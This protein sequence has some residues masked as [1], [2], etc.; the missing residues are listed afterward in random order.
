LPL[1]R[2]RERGQHIRL[3]FRKKP[4]QRLGPLG[5]G[6]LEHV[7]GRLDFQPGCMRAAQK[8]QT[9]HEASSVARSASPA[10]TP[11]HCPLL[12]GFWSLPTVTSSIEVTASDSRKC[13]SWAGCDGVTVWVT[14]YRLQASVKSSRL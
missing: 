6:D 4:H 2:R 13:P 9:V 10:V 14:P 8:Q 5:A 1:G 12:L 11:S 7:A 3:V